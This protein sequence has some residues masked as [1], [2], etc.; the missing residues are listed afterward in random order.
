MFSCVRDIVVFH[1]VMIGLVRRIGPTGGCSVD[2]PREER[3]DF[4]E[5]FGVPLH[6]HH[7]AIGGLDGFG[8]AVERAS[9]DPKPAPRGVHGLVVKAV[10]VN[11]V[12]KQTVW[13][14]TGFQSDLLR[15]V[16][17]RITEEAVCLTGVGRKVGNQSAPAGDVDDLVSSTYTQDRQ[18]D[19]P[20]CIDQGELE[21]VPSGSII[22][23]FGPGVRPYRLGSTSEPPLRTRA[24]RCSTIR[25]GSLWMLSR[26]G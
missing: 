21:F 11:A 20:G 24:S 10:H 14:G 17:T 18:S 13:D 3:V 1:S 12:A 23:E 19:F 15:S 16:R 9:D 8:D 5:E 4:D 2:E 7:G 25:R 6:A 22:E 26:I